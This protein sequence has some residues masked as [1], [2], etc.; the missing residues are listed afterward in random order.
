MTNKYKPFFA[1]LLLAFMAQF[2][3]ACTKD[4]D[5]GLQKQNDGKE[6]V[7]DDNQDD[8]ISKKSPTDTDNPAKLAISAGCVLCGKCVRTDPEHF[9]VSQ[10][11]KKV[12][13][14]SQEN[15]ESTELRV[16]IEICPADVIVRS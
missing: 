13:V 8:A 6:T 14:I 10:D 11:G 5:L 15:L 2:L 7:A 1:V 16:A 3:T 9:A 12:E 4:Q